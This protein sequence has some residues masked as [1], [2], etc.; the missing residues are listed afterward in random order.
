[1]QVNSTL[2]LL[3]YNA[4]LIYHHTPNEVITIDVEASKQLIED[5]EQTEMVP[6]NTSAKPKETIIKLRPSEYLRFI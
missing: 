1:M 5:S 4:K 6:F 3:V 2:T